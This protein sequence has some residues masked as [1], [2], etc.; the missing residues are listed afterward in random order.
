LV[1]AVYDVAALK[2]EATFGL[3]LLVRLLVLFCIQLF[4]TRGMLLE[5][6]FCHLTTYFSVCCSPSVLPQPF[7]LS[8]KA[9]LSKDE[10][11]HLWD[12]V[13]TAHQKY[14]EKE[15]ERTHEELY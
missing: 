14:L 3:K 1:A 10:A 9:D 13:A 2:V 7:I 5:P 6:G 8:L 4:T 11:A 12:C 15:Q